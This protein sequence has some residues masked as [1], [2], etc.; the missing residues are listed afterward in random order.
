LRRDQDLNPLSRGWSTSATE[1]REKKTSSE[2]DQITDQFERRLTLDGLLSHPL[3]SGLGII[4]IPTVSA[5]PSHGGK[6]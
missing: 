1:E 5:L 6:R 4:D 3:R 2:V